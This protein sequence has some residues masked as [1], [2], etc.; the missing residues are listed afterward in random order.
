MLA[1]AA[2]KSAVKKGARLAMEE[3]RQL[4]DDLSRT[5]DPHTCPH[6]CPIA[7]EISFHELLRRFK[8]I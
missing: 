1:A 3:I 4:L 7:V 2:C 5:S 6:G 8:R